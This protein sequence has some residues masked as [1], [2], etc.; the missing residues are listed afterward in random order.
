MSVS[1]LP[2]QLLQKIFKI[3]GYND[4]LNPKL[5][6]KS[7]TADPSNASSAFAQL[8]NM[9]VDQGGYEMNRLGT[10]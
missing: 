7:L 4:L 6:E 3:E 2:I 5:K 9:L 8:T 10:M 1:S